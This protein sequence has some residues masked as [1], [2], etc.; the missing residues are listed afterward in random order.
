MNRD[1]INEMVKFVG[2][3]NDFLFN[4]IFRNYDYVYF[5]VYKNGIETI[6][7]CHISDVEVDF[8]KNA[9]FLCEHSFYFCLDSYG[10]DWAFSVID[11]L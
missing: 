8:S 7:H 11:F 5:K 3:L 2:S 1:F 6:K 10:V 9:I 4:I